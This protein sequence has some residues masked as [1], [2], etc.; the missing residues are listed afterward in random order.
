MTL[1]NKN[2][3][4]QQH[5]ARGSTIVKL[6]LDDVLSAYPSQQDRVSF[7]GF[8]FFVIETF[9]RAFTIVL[10]DMWELQQWSI[11]LKEVGVSAGEYIWCAG[12]AMWLT[13]TP[14]RITTN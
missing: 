10:K 8:Q 7:G 5:R 14:C 4:I 13:C 2:L 6:N 9:H 1:S 11:A 3:I 12:R